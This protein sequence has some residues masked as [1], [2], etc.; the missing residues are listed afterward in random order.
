MN[1]I[2]LVG[3]TGKDPEIRFFENGN[4]VCNCSLAVRKRVKGQ[5]ATDWFNLEAWGKTGELLNDYVRKGDMVAIVG[6]MTSDTYQKDGTNR[7]KWY[8][9]VREL[10]LVEKKDRGATN[11]EVGT[12]SPG[13]SPTPDANREVPF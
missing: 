7:T 5:E 10:T 3:R 6:Q 9:K 8:V 2:S 11:D 12:S 13:M 1:S 4:V